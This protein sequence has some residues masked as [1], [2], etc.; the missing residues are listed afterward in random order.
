MLLFPIISP[1]KELSEITFMFIHAVPLSPLP[2]VLVQDK[3]L[4]LA[5]YYQKDCRHHPVWPPRLGS[6]SRCQCSTCSW[7]P[8]WCGWTTAAG[9]RSTGRQCWFSGSSPTSA[10]WGVCWWRL[11]EP[12]YRTVPTRS[13]HSER[14]QLLYK[15][16]TSELS[17]ENQH[18]WDDVLLTHPRKLFLEANANWIALS[19]LNQRKFSKKSARYERHGRPPAS[20]ILTE[21]CF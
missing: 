5:C 6:G 20:L 3:T 2:S 15:A 19:T 7:R 13:K 11:T 10:Q 1:S 21:S 18:K 17:M 8:V 16:K 12:E 4:Q 14:S 9:W